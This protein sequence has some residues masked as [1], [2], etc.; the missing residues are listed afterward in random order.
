MISKI[1]TTLL[2]ANTLVFQACERTVTLFSEINKSTE[3]H[4]GDTLLVSSNYEFGVEVNGWPIKPGSE[5]LVDSSFYV[6]GENKLKFTYEIDGKHK[7]TVRKIV[8]FPSKAPKELKYDIVKS[9]NHGIDIY[10][11]GL[12]L[13]N[14]KIYESGGEYKKSKLIK[15][16]KT[17]ESSREEYVYPKEI[18]AE[19]ITIMND[20][21]YGLS[22]R[23]HKIFRFKPNTLELIDAKNTPIDFEGWG[24][25]ND[26]TSLIMSDG[27]NNIY[28]L[29]P[30]DYSIGTILQVYSNKGKVIYV[31][32]LE[33]VDGVIYAN[34]F[35]QD[36]II[37]VD[38]KTGAVLAR[39][40]FSDI[41][42]IHKKQG[43]LNG[44][45]KLENGNFLITG[46]HWDKMYEIAIDK[47]D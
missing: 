2:I 29:S 38:A 6:I 34:V 21:L 18:F 9:Y 4:F 33:F 12:E 32:E 13:Y 43:V 11:E 23:E 28:Y 1:L 26:G 5:R 8:V 17:E 40:D 37:V 20:T 19:G 10:T 42:N 22:Y 3:Y 27:S 39:L 41:S 35:M 16:S 46:K 30:R 24:L 31:N 15:Y 45:A 14:D 36:V 44:I 47:I 25:T 7:S